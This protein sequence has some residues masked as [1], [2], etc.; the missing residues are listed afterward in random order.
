MFRLWGD[1]NLKPYAVKD[2]IPYYVIQIRRHL[3]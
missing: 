1:K 2:G 3:S